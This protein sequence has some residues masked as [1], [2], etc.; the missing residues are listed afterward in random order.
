MSLVMACDLTPRTESE[1]G[2][3]QT[4]I[5]LYGGSS[6]YIGSLARPTS[7][8]G[9]VF[10][11]NSEA[12]GS[13]L[14]QQ[15]TGKMFLVKTDR[16]GN[17]EWSITIDSMEQ[18]LVTQMAIDNEGNYALVGVHLEN[19]AS[20]D[21]GATN[22]NVR[23]AKVSPAGEVLWVQD[24]GDLA[25][26]T[27][28]FGS[29][30]AVA[31]NG[32][33]LVIG[34]TSS[35]AN[36]TIANPIDADVYVLR[37][38]SIDGGLLWQKVYGRLSPLADIGIGI[39]EESDGNIV[40]FGTV[41]VSATGNRMRLIKSNSEG[42]II[43]DF[44]YPLTSNDQVA[45]AL[46]VTSGGYTM[47]GSVDDDY[48]V[49]ATNK[50]GKLLWSN[51]VEQLTGSVIIPGAMTYASDGKLLIVGT[52]QFNN[53]TNPDIILLKLSASGDY[54]WDKRFG[55]GDLDIGHGVSTTADGGIL[56]SGTIGFDSNSLMALIKTNAAGKVSD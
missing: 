40:W 53:A 41:Q 30:I 20:T 26:L 50:D 36:A 33:Y 18:S 24:Y 56:V 15:Y 38:N 39:A 54:E 4:F 17:E 51:T 52:Y 14:Q 44:N 2:Q 48:V 29:N 21:G 47:M 12:E 55:A 35:N 7:D 31:S 43:W 23:V 42:N 3:E 32:D 5:K 11:G 37:I 22:Y 16:L 13:F 1:F 9:Y 34:H 6:N 25:G 19:L 49:M 10:A 46:L 45:G 27:A 8:G 28:D